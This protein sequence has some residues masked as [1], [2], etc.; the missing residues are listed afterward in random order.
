MTVAGEHRLQV[1]RGSPRPDHAVPAAA[2]EGRR[3][4]ALAQQNG[5]GDWETS[6]YTNRSLTLVR[7]YGKDH[8]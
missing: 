7:M 4:S 1:R 2:H 8:L 3:R 5:A 6:G